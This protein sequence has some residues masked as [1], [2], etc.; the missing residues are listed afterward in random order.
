MI[1]KDIKGCGF[2]HFSN[3]LN[4]VVPSNT[5]YIEVEYKTNVYPPLYKYFKNYI[6]DLLSKGT[7]TKV[8]FR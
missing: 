3:Y 1:D 2:I 7:F 4:G 8:L 5:P 6:E